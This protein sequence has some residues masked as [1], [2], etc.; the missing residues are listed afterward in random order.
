[1]RNVIC[2]EESRAKCAENC[3][4]T[5]ESQLDPPISNQ[6]WSFTGYDLRSLLHDLVVHRSVTAVGGSRGT[7]VGVLIVLLVS[8]LEV[9]SHFRIQLLRSLLGWAGVAGLLLAAAA[10]RTRT[11]GLA[12]GLLLLVIRRRL[13]L[14]LWLRDALGQS[15]R[16]RG[17]LGSLGTANDD[18]DLNWTVVNEDAVQS[19]ES[20]ASAIELGEGNSGNATADASRTVRN[21]H[22]LDGANRGLE[23]LLWWEC[24]LVI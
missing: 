8:G 4:R 3:Q 12:S 20:L 5:S 13:R 16:G 18:F 23:V 6:L 2:R 15:L 7:T 14:S 11:G 17:N 19:I 1:M 21:L 10:A 22:S 9:I 24:R